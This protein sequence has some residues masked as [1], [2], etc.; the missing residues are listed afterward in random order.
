LPGE[1][2]SRV[3]N[4]VPA[5]TLETAYCDKLTAF[6]TRHYLKWR[7]IYDLWWIGTQTEAKLPVASVARQFLHN[8][9][10]YQTLG[11]LSPAQALRKFLERDTVELIRKADPELK[12]WLPRA[13]WEKM[14]PSVTT[15]MVRYTAYSL[16]TVADAIENRCTGGSLKRV[17]P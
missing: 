6:A 17:E 5:A 1:I 14:H 13:L 9:S 12:R 3:S 16:Q 4:P 7:D 2:V 15:E 10:A 8:V 11:G